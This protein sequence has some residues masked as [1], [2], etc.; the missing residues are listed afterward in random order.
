MAFTT[1]SAAVSAVMSAAASTP[2]IAGG[3]SCATGRNAAA[4]APMSDFT[5]PG[6]STDT[7]MPEPA[8][9]R[10]RSMDSA[11]TPILVAA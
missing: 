6:N 10:R 11:I 5:S 3:A 7:S 1:I 2:G 9:D 4:L 8:S